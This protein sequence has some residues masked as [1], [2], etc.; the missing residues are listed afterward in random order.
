MNICSFLLIFYW[1]LQWIFVL[2]PTDKFGP[3]LSS[4]KLTFAFQETTTNGSEELFIPIPMD[5]YRKQVPYLSLREATEE[6]QKDCKSRRSHKF[7]VR[8]HLS[9]YCQSHTHKVSATWLPTHKLK[10]DKSWHTKM[11]QERTWGLPLPKCCRQLRNT[12][13]RR[14]THVLSLSFLVFTKIFPILHIICIDL[15][16]NIK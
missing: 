11:G 3:Y 13:S 9:W 12:D 7:T 6:R 14:N 10:K 5:T 16:L 2:R 4:R 15:I 8:L 1:A